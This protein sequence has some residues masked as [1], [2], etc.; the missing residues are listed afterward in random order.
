MTAP[1]P[2]PCQQWR[3]KLAAAHPDDLES[4]E[5][6]ALAAH[7]AT[8][9]SC[10]AVAAAYARMDAA[11]QRLPAPA[12]LAGVPPKLLALWADEDRQSQASAPIAL[13]QRERPLRSATREAETT[14]IFPQRPPPRR[15]RRLV[16][17]LTALAAVLVI[18]LLTAA[19]LASRLHNT[20][21]GGPRPQ[22]TTAPTVVTSQPTAPLPTPTA[23]NTPQ[24]YPVLVYFSHHP[25]SDSDPTAVIAVHRTSPNLGVA[26]FALEQLFLGPTAAEQEQGYYSDFTGNIGP[27]NNCSDQSQDFTLSLNHRGT[28][29]EAGTATVRLCRQVSIPGDFSGARMKAMIT[30][31]LT[32]FSNIKQVVILNDQGNCFDDLQ[33][34][35]ACLQ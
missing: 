15:P 16:S 35:N 19:L 29:S 32:Q 13:A 18:V 8:C 20:S 33:G 24:V 2:Q 6:A 12:P 14:P 7:L 9:P 21:S 4:A 26:T 23:T 25:E 3:L 31:T 34:A 5:R 28:K 30:K 11:V 17:G 1:L 22:Q 27:T 10:A